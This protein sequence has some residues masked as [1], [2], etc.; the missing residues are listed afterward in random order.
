[1][2]FLLLLLFEIPYVVA[3]R[4]PR[5]GV[6]QLQTSGDYTTITW[7]SSKGRSLAPARFGKDH[8]PTRGND[9]EANCSN[10]R[11]RA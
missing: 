10:R 6:I 1:M 9:L 4:P 3:P 2:V 7:A 8:K 5:P 11:C